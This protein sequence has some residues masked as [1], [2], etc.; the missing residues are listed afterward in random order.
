MA[1]SDDKIADFTVDNSL[2]LKHQQGKTCAVPDPTDISEIFYHKALMSFPNGSSAWLDGI[3]PNCERFDCQV[4]PAKWTEFSQSLNKS[5]ECDSRWKSTF[6]N[7]D[8]LLWCKLIAPK[9]PDGGHCRFAVGKTFRRLSAKCAGYYVFESRQARYGNRQVGVGPKRSA[10]LASHV[11]RRLIESPQPKE[12]VFLK[13][14]FENAF[15]SLKPT[16]RAR[17]NF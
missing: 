4:E 17:E 3:L 13:I 15:N 16:I 5:C 12:N 6:G 9:K 1:V 7:L 14:D 11:F 8:V 10:E 2:K